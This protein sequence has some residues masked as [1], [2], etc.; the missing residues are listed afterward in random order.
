MVQSERNS[1][2][3][4]TAMTMGKTQTDYMYQKPSSYLNRWLLGHSDLTQYM[5]PNIKCKQHENSTPKHKTI[6][7]TTEDL[8]QSVI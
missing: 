7:T 8:E 5:K 2:S 1:H 3:N 4:T 6:R